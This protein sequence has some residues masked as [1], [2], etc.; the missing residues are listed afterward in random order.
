MDFPYQ[1]PVEILN[2]Y[3]YG[4]RLSQSHQQKVL[5][6]LN[7]ERAARRE[8][9]SKGQN[10]YIDHNQFNGGFMNR[11]S[12]PRGN[13]P[14]NF[15]YEEER[16]QPF[17]NS[18]SVKASLAKVRNELQVS[19]NKGKEIT[20]KHMEETISVIPSKFKPREAQELNRPDFMHNQLKEPDF[21]QLSNIYE[22]YVKSPRNCEKY[23]PNKRQKSRQYHSVSRSS[24]APPTKRKSIEQMIQEKEEKFRE[25]CTFRPKINK[26]PKGKGLDY[27]ETE[28]N[29]SWEAKLNNLARPKTDIIEMR[30]RMK[31]EK[32]EQESSICTFKPNIT[33]TTR[34]V[35]RSVELT[36]EERLYQDAESK[37]QERE[38]L[39]REK[40]DI[41]AA[42]YPYQPQVQASV[43]KLVGT[44]KLKPPLYQ[45]LDEVQKERNDTLHRIKQESEENDPDL[46]FKPRINA[47]SA[48]LAS[49]R[50]VKND[51]ENMS[52]TE[53]LSKDASD[54][55]ERK[56]RLAEAYSQEDVDRYTFSPQ[57]SISHELASG[58]ANFPGSDQ[59]FLERQKLMQERVK[60]KRE[61]LLTKLTQGQY[62]FKP[63]IDKTSHYITASNRERSQEKLT[64][65]FERWSVKDSEKRANKEKELQNEQYS[66][67]TFEPQINKLSKQLG[68]T[69]SLNELAYNEESKKNLKGKAQAQAA[70]MEKVCSFTPKTASSKK[71]SHIGSS[72]SQKEDIVKIIEE[73]NRIKQQ[74]AEN[75]KKIVE[76]EEMRPCTFK[77]TPNIGRISIDTPVEVK[78]M[79]RFMELKEIQKRI[80]NEKKEREEK[81]FMKNPQRS[82]DAPY[83]VPQPFNLHP[84]NKREKVEKIRE[85]I[86][87][88]EQS[89]YT[90]RPQ[91]IESKNRQFVSK[92]LEKQFSTF[93]YD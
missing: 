28:K 55:L 54:K 39:K 1:G 83:T 25:E 12:T 62:T 59:D 78:G 13:Y 74:K 29:M 41:E 52:I 77:P 84:S 61:E 82:I 46:T 34:S 49:Y 66:K 45:R 47:Y 6:I 48:Q 2:D 31:R 71:F 42:N 37:F 44:K 72:Y 92:M 57:I 38:R 70:E 89:I 9:I 22:Q 88:R 5:G 67:Y 60:Q 75:L 68:R 33:T 50:K 63:Q 93:D 24:S 17:H 69:A 8:Q 36:V 35:N 81:V 4:S 58:A 27:H 56:Q 19:I 65:K 15:S 64:D 43:S 26:L 87:E 91:T 14:Q 18:Q 16:P 80:E 51:E 86:K 7:Q 73:Q 10:F 32:E 40:E 53:K 79:D 76:Y 3:D 23:E 85:E 11:Q 90:F 21:E 20:N 30:E